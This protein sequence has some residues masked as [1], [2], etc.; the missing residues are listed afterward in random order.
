MKARMVSA[1]FLNLCAAG[2][3]NV[4]Y[5]YFG[6]CGTRLLETTIALKS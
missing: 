2:V 4:C 6:I 1:V 3:F 5:Q